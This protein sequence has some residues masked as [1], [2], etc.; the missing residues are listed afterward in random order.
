MLFTEFDIDVAKTIWREEALEEGMEKGLKKGRAE[1]IKEG[2][3]SIIT[4][5]K[6]LGMSEEQIK[7]IVEM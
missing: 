1:G 5:M 3:N 7:A 4:N 6:A 2:I